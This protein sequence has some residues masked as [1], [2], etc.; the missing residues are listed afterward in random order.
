LMS[1]PP[2]RCCTYRGCVCSTTPQAVTDVHRTDPARAAGATTAGTDTGLARPATPRRARA[3]P[4][5]LEHTHRPATIRPPSQPPRAGR[6]AGRAARASA[7]YPHRP[8]PR[9]P[10]PP[11]LAP[12]VELAA[13]LATPP[14]PLHSLDHHRPPAAWTSLPVPQPT[15]HALTAAD[16]LQ[17]GAGGSLHRQALP[18]LFVAP[19]CS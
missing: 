19:G 3:G 4:P 13:P 5:G 8:L 9:L 11:Q 1:S 6:S 17:E 2:V 7:L 14:L 12:L 15:I 16:R 18:D 10:P